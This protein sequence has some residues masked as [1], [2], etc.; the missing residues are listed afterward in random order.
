MDCPSSDGEV[1]RLFKNDDHVIEA[2]MSAF[3]LRSSR[4]EVTIAARPS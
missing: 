4:I 2:F 3:L 1:H